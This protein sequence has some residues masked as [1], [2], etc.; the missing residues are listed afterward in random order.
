MENNISGMKQNAW[1]KRVS[2]ASQ[3]E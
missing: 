2:N 3:S 1:E